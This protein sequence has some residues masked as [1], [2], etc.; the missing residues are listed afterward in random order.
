[1]A[2]T[3][4]ESLTSREQEVLQLMARGQTNRQIGLR[5]RISEHT[6]KFHVASVL[7]KL[8]ARSRAEAVARAAALGWILL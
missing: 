5:L 8:D 1:V 6:V 3:P 7:S 2:E 4:V